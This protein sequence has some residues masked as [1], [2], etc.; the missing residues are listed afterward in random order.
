[1]CEK[2]E[3]GVHWTMKRCTSWSFEMPQSNIP[4][5]VVV[6]FGCSASVL[7]HELLRWS[8]VIVIV[9][10][11]DLTRCD[12][13]ADQPIG[14]EAHKCSDCA[15]RQHAIQWPNAFLKYARK[16]KPQDHLFSR[17]IPVVDCSSRRRPRS[18]MTEP[19]AP[20]TETPHTAQ[21]HNT[22]THVGDRTCYIT[23]IMMLFW[24]L[25]IHHHRHMHVTMM[26]KWAPSESR[27]A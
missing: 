2:S 7:V 5:H 13:H 16:S 17:S 19:D 3:K 4:T 24:W 1:M 21:T 23:M 12:V 9:D 27:E 8:N 10:G 22:H 20:A 26:R 15:A 18:T 6:G 11:D 25:I 14:S